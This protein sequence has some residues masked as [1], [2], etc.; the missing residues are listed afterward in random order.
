MKKKRPKTLAIFSDA[1][2]IRCGSAFIGREDSSGKKN[3]KYGMPAGPIRK[4]ILFNNPKIR[5]NI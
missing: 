2:V 3:G 4:K 5:E 1:A